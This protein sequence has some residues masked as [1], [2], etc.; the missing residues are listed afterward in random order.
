MVM[1]MYALASLSLMIVQPTGSLMNVCTCQLVGENSGYFLNAVKTWLI[2]N[3]ETH[4][5]ALDIFQNTQILITKEGKPYLG[6]AL[7]TS[8]E[9]I[10]TKA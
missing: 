8:L 2:T 7:G 6:E 9:F 3:D 4:T 10:K 1:P 5:R